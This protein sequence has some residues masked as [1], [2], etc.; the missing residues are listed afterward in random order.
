MK[1]GSAILLLSLPFAA[2]AA[3]GGM[4]GEA[5]AAAAAAAAAGAAAAL[6]AVCAASRKAGT[7]IV[8]FLFFCLGVMSRCGRSLLLASSPPPADDSFT[9]RALEGLCG[10]LEHSSIGGKHGEALSKALLCGVRDGLPRELAEAFR[11]SGAAHLLALSGLHLGIIYSV[12]R[13]LR[14]PFGGG[15]AARVGGAAAVCG[16][17]ALYTIITG[18]SPST[19]RA[20]IFICIHELFSLFAGRGKTPADTLG[21]ALFIQLTIMPEAIGTVGFRLSYAATAGTAL[22]YPHLLEWYPGRAR[23]DPFRKLWSVA[24]LSLSC[25]L[26]TAPLAWAYFRSFPPY[27]LITNI[28][29][30]P[31][32]ECLI[33]SALGCAAFCAAGW[34]TEVPAAVCGF[35]CDALEF[36]VRTVS[37]LPT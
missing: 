22:L 11:R 2:G 37:S 1:N 25:Q 23:N 29:A 32:T 13:K 14:L 36:C 21:A 5:R 30:L 15:L 33:V 27:F 31:I 34:S 26:F 20:L 18:A 17:C 19:V 4:A 6:L 28:I 35:L 8:L 9:A 24:A 3:A 7:P 16:A 10:L 12:L